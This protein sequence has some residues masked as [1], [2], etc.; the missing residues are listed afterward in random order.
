M[1]SQNN[2]VQQI[3]VYFSA[4]TTISQEI[5]NHLNRVPRKSD[6]K[7]HPEEGIPGQEETRLD[8]TQHATGKGEQDQEVDAE[9]HSL[10]QR[11][12]DNL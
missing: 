12:T 10:E 4:F 7:K 6:K 3:Q 2:G 9:G 8:Q 11:L 5:L 1:S